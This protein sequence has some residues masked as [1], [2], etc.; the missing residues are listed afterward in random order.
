MEENATRFG[1]YGFA[2]FQFISTR[3]RKYTAKPYKSKSAGLP[4]SLATGYWIL[5]TVPALTET[6]CN[7]H[8]AGLYFPVCT[9]IKISC[10]FCRMR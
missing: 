3:Y 6:A 10:T 8:K 4:C 5:T 2:E 7:F 9:K 1:L